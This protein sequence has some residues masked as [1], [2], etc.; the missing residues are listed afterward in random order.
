MALVVAVLGVASTLCLT[1]G[2][3]A[4]AGAAGRVLSPPSS[5]PDDCSVDVTGALTT[6]F[7]GLRSG[8]SV[9]LPW[10]ACYRVSST[11]GNT[12]E[13]SGLHDVRIL[14]D[15]ATFWQ[16]SYGNGQCGSNDIQPVLW[17]TSDSG[18]RFTDLTVSGPGTCSGAGNEGDY[19]I[20]LGQGESGNSNVVFNG[21][22]VENTDG[23]ALAVLPLLGT[24][25]GINT[26]I[27]FDNGNVSNIGYHV[28]TL[29]GVNG[30][31]F[32]GN[33]VSGF[34]SFADL[35]VDNDCSADPTSGCYDSSGVPTST[36]QW[37]VS[38]VENS[39]SDATGDGNWIESEQGSCIPQKNLNIEDNWLDNSVD[40]TIVLSGS[41]G[42]CRTDDHVTIANN[43]SLAPSH[44]PCGGSIA[45]PPACALIEITD[46]SDVTITNNSLAAF[47]G[48]P[49]YYANTLY[50]P[51]MALGNVHDALVTSN[52][53]NDTLP[54]VSAVGLQFPPSD[55][56]NTDLTVCDNAYG[57]T[58]PIADLGMATAP[59]ADPVFDG[60]C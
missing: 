59:P 25:T 52:A 23:D 55:A 19:G 20:L 36:A 41:G 6:W 29:E 18:L 51:C 53:C 28:L 3:P 21:V 43:V 16:S 46:Y 49:G 17:L 56:T 39:F 24:G 22:T 9:D 7:A 5:I 44:S 48:S 15:A 11:P 60:S 4:R 8:D 26:D 27:A 32:A 40:G 33:E 13:L 2:P 58:E 14:G 57:L 12:L 34:T 1:A 10:N 30:M 54:W 31:R 37:N 42:S 47:D 50:T 38:I 35:E 45:S